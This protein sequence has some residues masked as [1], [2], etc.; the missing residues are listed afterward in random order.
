MTLKECCKGNGYASESP[1]VR[2]NNP[3]NTDASPLSG[4]PTVAI[5][6]LGLGKLM[7]ANTTPK[8]VPVVKSNYSM[9]KFGRPKKSTGIEHSEKATRT[10]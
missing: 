6:A 8:K 7:S 5:G 1:G 2:E 9:E 3:K 4:K 10:D